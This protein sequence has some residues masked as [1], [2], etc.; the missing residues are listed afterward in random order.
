[1]LHLLA[2]LSLVFVCKRCCSLLPCGLYTTM[3]VDPSLL[4]DVNIF[5]HGMAMNHCDGK[6]L[7]MLTTD[8]YWK[9]ISKTASY[10]TPGIVAK[11]FKLLIKSRAQLVQLHENPELLAVQKKIIDLQTELLQC[12]NDQLQSLQS[13]VKTSVENTVKA[14]FQSYSNAVKQTLPQQT[15]AQETVKTIVRT[16]VQEEDRSKSFMVFNLEEEKE[17]ELISKVEEVLQELGEKPRIEAS[18]LGTPTKDQS[19]ARPVKVTLSSSVAVSQILAKAR[20]LR[21]SVKHKSVF[22][23]QDRSREDRSQHRLL[24]EECRKMR[25]A[26]PTKKFYIRGGV[27]CDGGARGT[28]SNT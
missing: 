4:T 22:L 27:V 11:T 26:E 15:I 18:R 21:D 10:S 25:E 14:E 16:V 9:N 8:V 2:L 1:M 3:P 19:K 17:E 23:C 20:R 13:T 12:K 28:N 24:V 6:G 7:D 5:L